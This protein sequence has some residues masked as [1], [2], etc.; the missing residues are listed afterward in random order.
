MK[1]RFISDADFAEFKEELKRRLVARTNRDLAES[2]LKHS[3]VMMLIM[4]KQNAPH[5]L[6]TRRTETVST[7]KG[8]VAFPGGGMEEADGDYRDAAFRET[9][10]EVG[11]ARDR[12]ELL[13]RF[14]DYISISGFHV[15]CFVG[16]VEYPY[17]YRL[18][19]DEIESHL[20]APLAMFVNQEFERF[21]LYNFQGRDY[22][23]FHYFHEGYEIWGL[24]ARILTDFGEKIC[25][26]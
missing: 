4:N 22:R 5:V 14:D 23:I 21:D 13:G 3:A 25:R 8:Q 19:P 10:E 11:I 7:H 1:M 9:F 20:E 17:Q 2:G 15:T 16:A 24:T 26:D 12:I 18:N 6:L